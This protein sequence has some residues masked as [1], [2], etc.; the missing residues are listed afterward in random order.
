MLLTWGIHRHEKYWKDPDA[1]DP[2]RFLADDNSADLVASALNEGQ[3]AQ[4]STTNSAY[5]PF[6]AGGHT[7]I[8]MNVAML[9]SRAVVA[10]LV[11]N[12][13]FEFIEGYKFTP[14][15]GITMNPKGGMPLRFKRR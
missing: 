9:E 13:D 8:G 10:F 6:Y 5:F 4:H 14:V 1:F 2:S 12:F 11:K 15:A 7:C 3:A